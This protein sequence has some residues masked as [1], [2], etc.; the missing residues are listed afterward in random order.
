MS[1]SDG[2]WLGTSACIERMT[3][4]SSIDSAVSAEELADFDA[5]LAVLAELERRGRARRRSG[6]RWAE[7]RRAAAWPA[8]LSSIGLGS[9]VSTCDGPPFMKRW[10]TRLALAGKCGAWGRS[11]SVEAAVAVWV[12][13][14]QV[15]EG[16]RAEA[17]AAAVEQFAAGEGQVF[18]VEW[19]WHTV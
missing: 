17:H 6:A 13:D 1:S 18:E 4:M 14:E 2:S 5:A 3:A 16:E 9:N 15:A 10:M 8:Y 11:G 7:C 12:P 19:M